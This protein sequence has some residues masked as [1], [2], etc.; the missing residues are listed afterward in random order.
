MAVDFPLENLRFN[1]QKTVTQLAAAKSCGT[2][3]TNKK[4]CLWL[5]AILSDIKNKGL[6]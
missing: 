5:L 1:R 3:C 4:S 2:L 6:F